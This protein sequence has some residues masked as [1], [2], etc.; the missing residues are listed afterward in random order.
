M[1]CVGVFFLRK[2]LH[3]EKHRTRSSEHYAVARVHEGLSELYIVMCSNESR[4]SSV[5]E[6]NIFSTMLN[7]TVQ[8]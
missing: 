3:G 8:I 4:T 6:K 5:W 7:N 2:W 1:R